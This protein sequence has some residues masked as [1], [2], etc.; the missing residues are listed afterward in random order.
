MSHSINNRILR[1]DLTEGRTWTE[2]PGMEFYRK[3][4]G[5]R[6][7]IAHYLLKELPQGA[8]P[9]G[10]ENMLIFAAG[11]VTG[12]PVPGN[13]RHSVG[14]KSPMSGLYGES[15]AGGYWGA[16]LKSA[17]WDGIIFTGK[18]EKPVYLW[19]KDDAVEIRDA[20]HLWGKITGD[21][22]AELRE[23]L[24]D[25]RVRVTQI[26]PAGENL[27]RFAC[28]VNDLNE[29]AGRAGMGAVMG[30]KNL[31]AIAVRGSTRPQP[32]DMEPLKRTAQWVARDTFAEG[33]PHYIFHEYG[34]G[35]MVKSKQLEGHVISHNFRD[36]VLE[37]AENSDAISIKENV[38]ERM[39]GCYSCSVNCKKRVRI[40]TAK[41]TVDPKYGGPEYETLAAIGSNL[42]VT[43]IM[44]V[45]KSAEMVNYLGLDSISAGSVL[46]WAMEM[47]EMGVIS[48][49]DL[50]GEELTF[51]RGADVLRWIEMIAYRKGFGDV[52]AEGA[53]HA[54]RKIGQDSGKY[55]M[56]VKGIDLG[57]H[58]PRAM[59]VMR[60]Q[61]AVAPVGG[62]HCG[63]AHK[64]N[65]LANT[66]GICQFLDYD[67]ELK[68]ELLNAATGWD[69]T[70]Q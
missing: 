2:A 26:G 19:I 48:P 40:E 62:D 15:E 45:C 37:G 7:F 61:F 50:G 6:M 5:G 46:A 42:G 14:A 16:E 43:D 44:A 41:M 22:E 11:P 8:D 52:L 55:V 56:A 13:A 49:E 21:V 30:S 1:V 53:T 27:V 32:A 47:V 3:Y 10:P 63:S 12:T 20:A 18:A 57:M 38:T 39:D 54:A 28:V 23:E 9:L 29:F 36:G 33:Q 68:L 70:L 25:N 66:L 69:M 35:A 31:K 51:G 60:R 24:G 4:V 17:G 67:D 58:D 34:T 65:S 64:R 59:E